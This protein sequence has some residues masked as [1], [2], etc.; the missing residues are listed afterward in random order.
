MCSPIKTHFLPHNREPSPV[1][2]EQYSEKFRTKRR[3]S[4]VTLSGHCDGETVTRPQT[5]GAV[6]SDHMLGVESTHPAQSDIG[7][8]ELLLLLSS[9]G[10]GS[11]PPAKRTRRGSTM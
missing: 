1:P 3:H 6:D 10:E 4:Q 9:S 7:A 11:L 5:A 8:A 2:D